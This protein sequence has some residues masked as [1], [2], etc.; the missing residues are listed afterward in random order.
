M[1]DNLKPDIAGLAREG[2]SNRVLPVGVPRAIHAPAREQAG[3]LRDPDAEHLLRQDVVHPLLQI[4]HPRRQSFGQTA[5]DLAQKHSGLRAGIEK[6]HRR[7]GPEICPLVAR[8]PRLRERIEHPVGKLRRREHLV[9][10]EVGDTRQHVRIAPAQ[11]KAG[12]LAH[13]VAFGPAAANSP[14]VIGG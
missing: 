14:T 10:G 7:V 11:G 9:V 3:D 1:L 13:G 2:L 6:G 5:G 4:R 12:L 8:R